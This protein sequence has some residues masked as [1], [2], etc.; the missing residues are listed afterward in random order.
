MSQ[1]RS[2]TS[3]VVTNK[4]HCTF[5]K[6]D[7]HTIFQ[8]NEFTKLNVQERNAQA[9]NLKLCLNCLRTNHF[10]S[11]CQSK[12]KCRKCNQSHNMLLHKERQITQTNETPAQVESLNAHSMRSQSSIILLSTAIVL[13]DDRNNKSHKCRAL[14]D[15]GSMNSYITSSFSK[16][17]RLPQKAVNIT[18]G[19][20]G[21]ISTNIKQAVQVNI[22]SRYN[23][24]SA[25]LSCFVLEKITENQ[26]PYRRSYMVLVTHHK[27]HMALL[28]I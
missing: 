10:V 23:K 19:G 18:V 4:L 16:K 5:C 25:N 14:L 26:A 24:F 15:A 17:L 11:N 2:T 7:D 9:R 13:I 12:F 6:N 1:K 3:Y 28:S 8:C 21:Q 27:S 20:I 22:K